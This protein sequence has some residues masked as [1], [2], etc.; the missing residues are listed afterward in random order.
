MNGPAYQIILSAAQMRGAMQ[1][2]LIAAGVVMLIVFAMWAIQEWGIRKSVDALGWF[3]VTCLGLVGFGACA[4]L[5]LGL[6]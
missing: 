4:L 5:A 6:L 3:G 2:E 1:R